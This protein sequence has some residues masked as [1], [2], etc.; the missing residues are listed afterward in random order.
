M[1]FNSA[2]VRLLLAATRRSCQE[3]ELSALKDIASRQGVDWARVER[4]AR[5]NQVMPMLYHTFKH[6]GTVPGPL[7][8]KLKA[9]SIAA[10]AG[11]I[12]TLEEFC[13]TMTALA[14]AGIVAVPI[15]GAA[16]IEELY[17]GQGA[18]CLTDID[19]MVRAKDMQKVKEAMLHEGYATDALLDDFHLK[20][21]NE[22]VFTR[23]GRKPVDFH[24]RLA[25]TRYFHFPDDYW[26]EGLRETHRS[27]LSPS[28]LSPIPLSPIPLSPSTQSPSTLSLSTLSY[29]KGFIFACVH[30]FQHGFL[31]LR[32]LSVVERML[33]AYEGR[34]NWTLLGD[35]AKEHGS[36]NAVLFSLR[37]AKELLA[38]PAPG[39]MAG[40]IEN[41]P[42]REDFIYGRI[43]Q[44]VLARR[45]SLSWIMLLL[46]WLQFSLPGVFLHALKW[47]FP[48]LQ[49]ISI[50]YKVPMGSPRLYVLYVL[51]P[52][53]LLFQKPED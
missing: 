51:N 4:L 35:E 5:Q 36:L 29:E 31:K 10:E 6:L 22:A 32:F 41:M 3:D 44:R 21:F 28:P 1:N 17:H 14:S 26:W 9:S 38:A 25:N 42:A 30:L 19:I 39:E 12:R 18:Y 24:Y 11:N 49:E 46:S 16:L 34:I 37:L 45:P 40:L 23:K 43:K 20:R 8:Q 7:M 15:K 13:S 53:L 48:P 50:R 52:I 2:P 47:V 27:P 33:Y